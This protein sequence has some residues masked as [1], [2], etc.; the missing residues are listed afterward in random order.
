M[1]RFFENL[2][3]PYIS[4]P[5]KDHPPQTLLAFMLDY[6]Q[7]FK[8]VFWVTGITSVLVA[9]VEIALI[10]VMGWIVDLLQEHQVPVERVIATGG[11][12][13]RHPLV[14]Q[15]YA[16]VLGMPVMVHPSQQGPAL[17]A[18]LLGALA[19]GAFQTPQA[20]IRAMATP[21]RGQATTY[22]PRSANRKVYDQ[23]YTRYRQLAD[24]AAARS[25]P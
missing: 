2:V 25:V 21:K 22:R 16:D 12:P 4:Y 1:F 14:V 18:A 24:F 20:A 13:H 17:G 15:V 9:A 7:P 11:L 10:W 23:L 6:A 5:Q 19:G 3:D 8:R